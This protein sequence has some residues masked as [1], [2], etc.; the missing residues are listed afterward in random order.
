V[1]GAALGYVGSLYFS[2]NVS[3][4]PKTKLNS[5]GAD[6]FAFMV[7]DYDPAI[8]FFTNTLGFNLVEDSPRGTSKDGKK[9]RWVSVRHPE[10]GAQVIIARADSEEQRASIG[11]QTGDRVGF[12]L[13]VSNFEAAVAKL[14]ENPKVK[15]LEEPRHEVYGKVVV[16]QDPY[17]NK[18][19]LLC[20]PKN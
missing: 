17:G 5:L 9:K 2:V 8:E 16:F 14:K 3:N 19:D 11:R 18:W 20:P 6:A 13:K 15:L 10:G 4:T 12:F 7:F 1:V